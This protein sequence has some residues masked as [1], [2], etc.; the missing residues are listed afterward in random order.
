VDRPLDSRLELRGF[1]HCFCSH[2]LPTGVRS[3]LPLPA[4]SPDRYGFP[5]RFRCCS[6][7]RRSRLP[8]PPGWGLYPS[9]PAYAGCTVRLAASQ[10]VSAGYPAVVSAAQCCFLIRRRL[11]LV[12]GT[13]APILVRTRH[14]R[15]VPA[16]GRLTALQLCCSAASSGSCSRSPECGFVHNNRKSLPAFAATSLR[17]FFTLELSAGLASNSP[18][19]LLY[20]TNCGSQMMSL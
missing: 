14:F 3:K 9:H 18:C 16:V 7:Q 5:H 17:P 1:H 13:C 8:A 2:D 4:S 6:Q 10:R 15:A 12:Q 19:G 11:R 20:P